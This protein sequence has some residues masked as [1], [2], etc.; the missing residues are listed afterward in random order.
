[1]GTIL[2]HNAHFVRQSSGLVL[3]DVLSFRF[4]V[5]E[6]LP[7]V[8]REYKQLPIFLAR[9]KSII[10]VQNTDNR[11][12]GY[13][14]ASALAPPLDHHEHANRPCNYNYLFREK[15]LDQLTYPVE[16]A[17]IPAIEDKLGVGI[18]V[19]SFFD[20]EGKGR[21]PLYATEK[22]LRGRSTC[23]TGMSITPGSKTSGAS[24]PISRVTTHCTGVAA[25]WGTSTLRMC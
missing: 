10:N 3:A 14:M 7:L 20:D 1:M 2:L 23:S 4:K 18:N 12:F 21:Y 5:C 25:V 6:Y 15:G 17:S 13:A 8:G 16:V 11:C 24:W 19:Y 9:K 22:V